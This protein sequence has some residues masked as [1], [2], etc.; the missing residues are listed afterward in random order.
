VRTLCKQCS[1]PHNAL[2][3]VVEQMG[4]RR[5][6][7]ADPVVLYKP[8]GC[9]ACSG[10]GY[11]G[12]ICIIE[13]LTMSDTIRSLVMRHATAGELR[14]AAIAEGMETM[15]ENGLRKS[16]AGTTTIEEVLRV[17]REE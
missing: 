14:A 7:K 4:L 17:T 11:L 1:E 15:F 3:E 8:V 12:R 2:P 16:L 9:P 13:M 5:F 10:T 6:T